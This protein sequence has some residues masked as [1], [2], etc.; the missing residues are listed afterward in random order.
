MLVVIQNYRTFDG[1]HWHNLLFYPLSKFKKKS[2]VWKATLIPSSSNAAPNVVDNIVDCIV[3]KKAKRLGIQTNSEYR[4]C[5]EASNTP[6][7]KKQCH[8]STHYRNFAFL[9][10]LDQQRNVQIIRLIP[11]R[12]EILSIDGISLVSNFKFVSIGSL[13]Y[14]CTLIDLSS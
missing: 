6:Y 2:N 5:H 4:K 13:Y 1:I 3:W 12:S 11:W 9:L 14:V 8:Q 7:L 10:S